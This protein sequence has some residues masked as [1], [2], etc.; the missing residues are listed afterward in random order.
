MI[1]AISKFVKPNAKFYPNK[2][3]YIKE[4][5]SHI[6]LIVF[7]ATRLQCAKSCLDISVNCLAQHTLKEY[8]MR[9]I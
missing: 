2:N 1:I 9:L 5:R 4:C 6:N 8:D 7:L 3:R